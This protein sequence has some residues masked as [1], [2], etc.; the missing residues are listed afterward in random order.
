MP[1][2]IPKLDDRNYQKLLDEALARI[3]VHT[4]EWTNFNESDPGVTLIE[5]FAFLTEN[6]QYRANLIPERNRLKFLSLLGIPLQPAASAQGL[7]T[8]ASE[9]G[10]PVTPLNAG[11]ELLAGA[12]P[13]RT[14]LGI[15][16]LPI[17]ARVYYKRTYEVKKP[18]LT[19]YYRQL[20]ASYRG[21]TPP[22]EPDF[23]LYETVPLD[24]K[25]NGIN[26]GTDAIDSSLWIALMARPKENPVD[27]RAVLAGKVLN[28]GIAPSL[29]NAQAKIKPGGH[30]NPEGETPLQYWIPQIPD[31]GLLP[32]DPQQRVANYLPLDVKAPTNV[33]DEPGV[34]QIV[35]PQKP[36]GLGLWENLDPLEQ[37]VGDFPPALQDSALE[38][39]VI[40]WIRVSSAAAHKI[41]LLWVGINAVTISQRAQIANERLPDG[42]G[43]PD[44]SGVLSKTP[45]IPGTVR[46]T[47]SG[48]TDTWQEIDDLTAAGP[49]VPIADPR[50]PPGT[51]IVKNERIKVFTLDRESGAIRFGDGMRGK[52][53]PLNAQIFASYQY[54]VGRDGNVNSGAIKDAPALPSGIKVTNP[55]ATW[56]GA[57]GESVGEGE[58]Q[59]TRYLQHRDRLVSA[60]DFTAITLRTPGVD[61]G[62]VEV[63]PAFNPELG[64]NEPGDAPGAVTLMVLPRYD[65]KQ[66]DAPL[67]EK[68][69]IQ[70][71]C[72]HLE[73][74]RLVTTEVFL[75]GPTY[76]NIWISAGFN[77]IAGKSTSIAEV[78]EAVRKELYRFLSPLPAGTNSQGELSG[79]YPFTYFP[80]G[81]PLWNPVVAKEIAAVISRVAG[82]S[83]VNG[84]LLAEDTNPPGDQVEMRGLELPRI[85]GLSLSVGDPLT[86]DQLRGDAGPGQ[87]GGGNSGSS[88][89]FLPIPLILEEC[90]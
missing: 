38:K 78:R 34:V 5:L 2:K 42:T 4:P 83:L 44:Q 63:I 23:K 40:T 45:V 70:S 21:T 77:V 82:V 31:Q 85:M 53:P 89:G 88:S 12:V 80:Q 36:E 69:F 68:P 59:I 66:P 79:A 90:V 32:L 16:L 29:D 26:L 24:G 84:V 87:P 75:R 35:L 30:A 81:W 9:Q 64:S 46:L 7:V 51:V 19:E 52:R 20:Y 17:E 72:S 41:R 14:T 56:G 6:L 33:L 57:E 18:E 74:R 43:E 13:F 27:L 71:I 55:I 3:P 48:D 10:I 86:L 1:L 39:R 73:S 50:K 8:F 67:P 11:L 37:G 60:E 47:I 28:L 54:G 65:A 58:K 25:E 49:E 76:K 15:D 22:S 61:I 62:R